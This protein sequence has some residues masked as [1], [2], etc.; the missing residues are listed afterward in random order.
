MSTYASSLRAA[1]AAVAVLALSATPAT[2]QP[3]S[4]LDTGLFSF[5]GFVDHP[6]TA[7]SASVALAD[8]WL[9]DD[10]CG[11]PAVARANVVRFSPAFVRVSRQDLRADNRNYDETPLFFDG[12]SAS[13]VIAAPFG[14]AAAVYA[15][16]P[17]LRLE[18][19]AFTRGTGTVEPGGLPPAVIQ[20]QTTARELRAGFGVSGGGGALRVGAALDYT[21]RDDTYEALEESGS[22]ESGLRTVEFSGEGVGGSIG[23]AWAPSTSL[24]LAGSARLIPALDLEG[25][26]RLDL[27]TGDSVAAIVGEREAAWEAGVSVRFVAAEGLALLGS[28]GGRGEQAWEG[29]GVS[30]GAAYQ[31]SL[32]LDYRFPESTWSVRF[33]LG[34]EQQSGVPEPRATRIGLGFGWDLEGL[35]LDAGVVR[36]SLQHDEEPTSYDD[37]ILITARLGF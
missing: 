10:P 31:G 14:L 33:G 28:L 35:I 37:R 7:L 4:P 11:N 13:V 21:R 27:F 18:D 23:A 34:H 17:V 25:E 22:P 1:L 2:S 36:R 6:F 32:A 8:R 20:S 16:Q 3:P 12:A 30:A 5:P 19:N 26:Q 9:G 15:W 29:L 24:T